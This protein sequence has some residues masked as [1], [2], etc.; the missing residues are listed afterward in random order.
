MGRKKKIVRIPGFNKDGT[1]DKRYSKRHKIV[2][3]TDKMS[4]EA[5]P[6]PLDHAPVLYKD[7]KDSYSLDD[8]LTEK[9]GIELELLISMRKDAINEIE[10]MKKVILVIDVQI[11]TI[12]NK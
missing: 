3:T 8:F 12:T 10:A 6:C 11:K 7:G 4:E 2:A 1:I 9:Q 5:L